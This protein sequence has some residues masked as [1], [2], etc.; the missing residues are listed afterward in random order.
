MLVHS[1]SMAVR[2]CWILAGTG[3]RCRIWRSRASQTCSMGDMSGEYAGHPRTGMFSA[4]RNCVQILAT[5][6]CALSCC[7]MRWWSWMNGTTMGP[8]SSRYLC[9]FKMPSMSITYTCP[10][11]NPTATMG[12][13]IRNI[14]IMKP[15]T[16]TMSCTLSAI[17][18]VQWKPWFIREK[19]ISPKCQTPSNVSICPLKS[20]KT[21]NCSQ[22]KTLMRKTSM[23]MSFPQTVSD[24]LCRNSLVMQTDCCSSCPGGWSQTILEVK[25]LAVEVLG[26]CGYMCLRLWGWLDVLPNSLKCFWRRLMVEKWTFNSRATALVDIPAVSMPIATSVTLC[27]VIKLH[28]LEWPF[29]VASL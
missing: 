23:Q 6:G 12:H 7:N 14:D 9:A 8:I 4:S 10:Y 1:S 28:I 11:H 25:M 22:V 2:S 5:W 26:W 21:T 16:H 3:T 20:V 19:N 18:P 27:C 17:W 13:S 24:S 15:L 29:I